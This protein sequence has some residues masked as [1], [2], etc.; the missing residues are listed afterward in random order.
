MSVSSY[1]ELLRSEDPAAKEAMVS[2]VQIVRKGALVQ[3]S[4]LGRLAVLWHTLDQL[5]R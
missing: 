3:I 2:W 1:V 4:F 5:G